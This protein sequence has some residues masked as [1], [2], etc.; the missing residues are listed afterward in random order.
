M[1]AVSISRV[2]LGLPAITIGDSRGDAIT[3]MPGWSLGVDDAENEYAMS[4]DLPGA[5]LARSRFPMGE[6]SLP[7]VIRTASLAAFATKYQEIVRAIRQASF[8]TTVAINGGPAVFSCSPG[9]AARGYDKFLMYRG[10]DRVM[11]TIPRQ[12]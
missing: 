9:S 6:L 7:I 10:Q 8:T 4:A 1:I 12:P 3:L 2:S 5:S 11:L